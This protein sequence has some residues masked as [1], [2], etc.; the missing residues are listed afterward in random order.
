MALSRNTAIAKLDNPT[1][2]T[3][4]LNKS[5]GTETKMNSTT[6][7]PRLDLTI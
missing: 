1:A 2:T 3:V 4:M 7:E 5:N 6:A